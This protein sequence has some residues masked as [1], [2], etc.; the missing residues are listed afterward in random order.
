MVVAIFVYNRQS[1]HVRTLRLPSWKPQRRKPKV[2]QVGD[3]V[4]LE[5][6]NAKLLDWGQVIYQIETISVQMEDKNDKS[7]VELWE[8]GKL[9]YLLTSWWHTE[10]SA[11]MY[12]F[13]RCKHNDWLW[14]KQKQLQSNTTHEKTRGGHSKTRYHPWRAEKWSELTSGQSNCVTRICSPEQFSKNEEPGAPFVCCYRIEYFYFLY[15]NFI[16]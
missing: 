7:W 9:S 3:H 13:K 16:W 6:W 14:L 11:W 1:E 8:K 2:K 12:I 10:P 15:M 5:T 4:L